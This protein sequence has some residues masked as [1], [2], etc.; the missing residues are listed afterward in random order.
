LF[1]ASLR[2]RRPYES[3][4][5]LLGIELARALTLRTEDRLPCSLSCS[6]QSE[7]KGS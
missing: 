2:L 7:I 3:D 1:G 6:S 5:E 4:I